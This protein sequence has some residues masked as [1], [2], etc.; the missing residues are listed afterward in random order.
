LAGI[1]N[2]A[3]FSAMSMALGS[4]PAAWIIASLRRLAKTRGNAS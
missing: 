3:S 4:Y 1:V 2:F